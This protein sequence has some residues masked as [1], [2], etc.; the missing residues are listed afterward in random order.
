MPDNP[1]NSNNLIFFPTSS[2]TPSK[3]VQS[4]TLIKC[5]EKCISYEGG[6]SDANNSKCKTRCG[7]MFSQQSTYKQDCMGDFKTCYKTCGKE[8]IG[9][10]SSCHKKCKLALKTCI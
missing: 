4:E 5:M 1:Y 3:K 6:S 7:S 10:L 8:E 2:A 9:Q